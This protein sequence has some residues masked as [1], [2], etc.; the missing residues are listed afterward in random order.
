MAVH[1]ILHYATLSIG[2]AP[3]VYERLLMGLTEGE[4]D[5]RPDPARFTIR[6]AMAH[7]A[8]W[9]GVFLQRMTATRDTNNPI[10]QGYDEGQWAIDHDYAHADVQEQLMRFREGRTRLVS[11]VQELTPEQYTR[12]GQ[13]TEA[14]PLTLADQVLLVAVHDGYHAR[15]FAEWRGA[16]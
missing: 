3:E 1:R 14:G 7:L 15:Q 16:P 10:L 12:T 13:H 2:G 8:D 6:E 4:A 5:R 9:E 11:F